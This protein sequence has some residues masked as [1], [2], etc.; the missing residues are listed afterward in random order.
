MQI[1]IIGTTD[2]YLQDRLANIDES[3]NFTTIE[4]VEESLPF[5]VSAELSAILLYLPKES[6]IE[7]SV[8]RI[9]QK[10]NM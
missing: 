8:K 9:E 6:G 2:S 7:F 5:I 10:L 1:L 4:T 3:Y